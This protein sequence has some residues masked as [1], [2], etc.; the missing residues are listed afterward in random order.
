M[1]CRAALCSAVL[2]CAVLCLQGQC[3]IGSIKKGKAADGET[4]GFPKQ[5]RKGKGGGGRQ[6]GRRLGLMWLGH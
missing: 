1:L 2:C 3:G 5:H 4:S 6:E